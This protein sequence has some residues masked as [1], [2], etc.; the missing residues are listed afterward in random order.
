MVSRRVNDGFSRPEKVRSSIP[1]WLKRDYD[2]LQGKIGPKGLLAAGVLP[3]MA[4]L[5]ALIGGVL[6]KKKWKQEG[7][8]SCSVEWRVAA[9]QPFLLNLVR[10]DGTTW[11]REIYQARS[12]QLRALTD[13]I[14]ILHD[15]VVP[16]PTQIK[17]P[18]KKHTREIR[19]LIPLYE[20]PALLLALGAHLFPFNRLV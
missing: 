15:G 5:G 1:Q 11:R 17:F 9:H 8:A 10:V 3:V 16:L 4:R 7:S 18:L 6:S 14:R 13:V 12:D 20:R 2:P 19:R